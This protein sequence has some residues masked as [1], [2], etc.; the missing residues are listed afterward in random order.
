MKSRFCPP[1]FAA[2]LLTAAAG[3]S[4]FRGTIS[5]ELRSLGFRATLRG[6]QCVL[7]AENGSTLTITPG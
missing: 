4:Q 3:C 2:L 6:E 7:T 1:L 5:S